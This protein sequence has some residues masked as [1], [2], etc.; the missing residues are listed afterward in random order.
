MC[1]IRNGFRGTANTLNS[2]K[3]VDKKN[4]LR[5]VSNAYLRTELS[6]S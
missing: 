6:P 5:T 2:S 1:S 3:I 4:I